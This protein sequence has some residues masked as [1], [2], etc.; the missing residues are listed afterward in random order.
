[1]SKV[2]IGKAEG[3]VQKFSEYTGASFRDWLRENEGKEFRIEPVKKPVS[4]NLRHFYFGAVIPVLRSTCDEWATLTGDELHQVIKKLLFYF[5]TFNPVAGRIE[6]FGR[7]VM[8]N[9]DWNNTHKATEFLMIIQDYLA[10]CGRE[11]PDSE[12]YKRW[13]DSSP[14]KGEEYKK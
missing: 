10:Q 13:R 4:S 14:L 1:M 2:W 12:D 6:R 8:A 9:D 3:G 5:E 7:S 11:M